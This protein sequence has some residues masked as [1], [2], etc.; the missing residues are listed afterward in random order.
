MVSHVIG[1]GTFKSEREVPEFEVVHDC[2]WH[3]LILTP[4]LSTTKVLLEY[5]IF[6]GLLDVTSVTF[7]PLYEGYGKFEATSSNT[8]REFTIGN[9]RKMSA[10]EYMFDIWDS[11][12]MMDNKSEKKND[13][14]KIIGKGAVSCGHE[15]TEEFFDGSFSLHYITFYR[16]RSYESIVGAQIIGYEWEYLNYLGY[17]VSC[18]VFDS[19]EW[20]HITADRNIVTNFQ[21]IP[22]MDSD[23]T[24]F[25]K[26]DITDQK[27]NFDDLRGDCGDNEIPFS[28]L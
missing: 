12:P 24:E 5:E 10:D 4:E 18:V 6:F 3:T 21:R 1:F 27:V 16:E 19:W 23:T 25:I 28:C 22:E 20:S 26:F 17:P 14:P 15:L 7:F 11:K 8:R 2:M 13:P 9:F